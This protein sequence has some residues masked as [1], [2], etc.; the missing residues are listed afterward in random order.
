MIKFNRRIQHSMIALLLGSAMLTGCAAFYESAA[1]TGGI[2]Y[3]P[4]WEAENW[5]WHNN[6]YNEPY[7]VVGN[8]YEQYQPA[9]RYGVETYNRYHGQPFEGIDDAELR[10]G[11]EKLHAH[12]S[13][14]DWE[15]ARS[16]IRAAYMHMVQQHSGDFRG[17]NIDNGY[18]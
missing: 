15:H 3:E 18:H 12:Y 7:Y 14:L 11:W 17:G 6:Y 1:L 5:Y 4:G 8:S 2:A 10:T 9:Y 13:D 16:A